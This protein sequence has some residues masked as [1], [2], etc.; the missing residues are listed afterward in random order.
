MASAASRSSSFRARSAAADQD[1]VLNP[2]GPLQ[3][4]APHLVE[5]PLRAEEVVDLL[6]QVL[7]LAD[8]LQGLDAGLGL[9]AV[10]L[11]DEPRVLVQ[12]LEVGGGQSGQ[13]LH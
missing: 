3:G 6:A 10:A 1:P 13:P 2:R 11:L 9:Q 8:A 12:P 5:A 7:H 4:A